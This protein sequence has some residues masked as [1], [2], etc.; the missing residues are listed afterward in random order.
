MLYVRVMF[1]ILVAFSRL[2]ARMS[3]EWGG[4]WRLCRD[5]QV[6]IQH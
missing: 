4:S 3:D 5:N 2:R 6:Q 1:G